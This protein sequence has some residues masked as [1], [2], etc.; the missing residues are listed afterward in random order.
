MH[1]EK[2]NTSTNTHSEGNDLELDPN[3]EPEPPTKV[4]DK[5]VQ[6]AGKRNAGAEAPLKSAGAVG[7][8]GGKDQVFSR[9]D[10]GT[11]YPL[12]DGMERQADEESTQG[13]RRS[14]VGCR[15]GHSTAASEGIC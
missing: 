14:S 1:R 11:W 4:I 13:R 6:R 3:R 12:R 8:R 10:A 2:Q 15:D 7:G 9:A 5:P